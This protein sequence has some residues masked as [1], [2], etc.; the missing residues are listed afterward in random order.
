[1]KRS[2]LTLPAA[3]SLGGLVLGGLALSGC[4]DAG[5]AASQPSTAASMTPYVV[6]G[7][8][9]GTGDTASASGG[10]SAVTDSAS[11]SATSSASGT[12]SASAT[13]STSAAGR[14]EDLD[15]AFADT[16]LGDRFVA[17]RAVIGAKAPDPEGRGRV[18]VLVRVQ[19]TAGTEG[20]HVIS[21][22]DFAF[23]TET[24]GV[25]T[26]ATGS[27]ALSSWMSSHGYTPF[28]NV[29]RGGTGEGWIV[30][31]AAPADLDGASLVYTRPDVTIGTDPDN[32]KAYPK[33][34]WS[35]GL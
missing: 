33:K 1:M 2:L 24:G 14:T 28:T 15:Y 32:G 8:T 13:P 7:A 10:S 31:W 27:D 6:G 29:A 16:D 34:S 11:P 26:Q 21:P 5:T 20:D 17:D 25:I 9:A 12:P 18:L 30:G 23:T 3:L 4:S 19:A 22:Q 35:I